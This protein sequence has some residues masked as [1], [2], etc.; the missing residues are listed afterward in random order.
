MKW[1]ATFM[2]MKVIL[3]IKRLILIKQQKQQQK[4]NSDV[5]DI[6]FVSDNN[7]NYMIINDVT[8]DNYIEGIA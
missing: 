5:N 3:L 2:S 1:Y 4:C 6:K 7:Q 8:I